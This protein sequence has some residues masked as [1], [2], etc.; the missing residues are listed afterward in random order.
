MRRRG[1]GEERVKEER[2]AEKKEGVHLQ[3][4]R[5]EHTASSSGKTCCSQRG[6]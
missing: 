4:C 3:S 2:K 1:G 5:K 6:D